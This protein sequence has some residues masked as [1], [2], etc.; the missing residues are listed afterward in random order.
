MP[1]YTGDDI[2]TCL[3]ILCRKRKSYCYSLWSIVPWRQLKHTLTHDLLITTNHGSRKEGTEKRADPSWDSRACFAIQVKKNWQ[4]ISRVNR[5]RLQ[6]WT[7]I[8]STQWNCAE[9]R[10][11]GWVEWQ[12]D[13]TGANWKRHK[14]TGSV[15]RCQWDSLRS[16]KEETHPQTPLS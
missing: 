11:T 14:Y 5:P 2:G 1:F 3:C 4:D 6:D 8:D 9:G 10:W 13:L 12:L 7:G 15:K 16:F